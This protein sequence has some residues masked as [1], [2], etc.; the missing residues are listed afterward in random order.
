MRLTLV[1]LAFAG[2]R[3]R[4]LA[5]VLTI[6][7]SSAAAAT[8]VLALEVGAT[9]REPWQRTFDAANGAHVIATAPRSR[10]R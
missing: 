6:L 5:S 1:R 3:S 2:I 10:T 8:I 7:L 9:A 4:L